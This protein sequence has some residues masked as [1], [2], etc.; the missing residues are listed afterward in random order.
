M[1]GFY[2]P[3]WSFGLL[4]HGDTSNGRTGC[5][6]D[7]KRADRSRSLTLA[8]TASRP[9]LVGAG[10]LPGDL[11]P[12]PLAL[13]GAPARCLPARARWRGIPARY[14]HQVP[15]PCP[16]WGGVRAKPRAPLRC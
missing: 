9:A 7:G 1:E 13:A 5:L 4:C 3:Y 14:L 8:L 6:N 12:E 16:P 10:Y 11:H 2:V 15:P